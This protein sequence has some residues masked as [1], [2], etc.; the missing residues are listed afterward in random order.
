MTFSA[1]LVVADVFESHMFKVSEIMMKTKTSLYLAGAMAG[2]TILAGCDKQDEPQPTVN[3]V[4][5]RP[6][7]ALSTQPAETAPAQTQVALPQEGPPLPPGMAPVTSGKM[8]F[9]QAQAAAAAADGKEV[10]TTTSLKYKDIKVGTGAEA[11]KGK[12]AYVQYTGWLKD[13]REFD[14]SYKRN[15]PF[16]FVIGRGAVIA[17]WDEGVAGMKVGGRRLLTIP[18]HLGYGSA[19]TVGIPG[20]AT[21]YFDVEL[22]DLK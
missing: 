2:I 13:G 11:G 8:D 10:T 18:A 12:R 19:G 20:G 21:L 14:S 1:R 4:S 3:A 6:S 5:S 7:Y 15:V 17:G 22:V 16:D 9:K